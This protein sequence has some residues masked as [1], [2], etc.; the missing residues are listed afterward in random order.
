VRRSAFLASGAYDGRAMF[1]NL[2][3]M[4]TILAAGGTISTPLDL[5]VA[6]RPPSSEHFLSQR[7]RQAYDDFAIPARIAAFLAVWPLAVGLAARGRRRVV[8]GGAALAVV[9]AEAGRRRAGGAER[10][11]VTASLLAP[12]W[13]AER[14]TCAWLALGAKLQGGVRYGSG[15]LEHSATPMRELRRRYAA[16]SGEEG[17]GSEASLGRPLSTRKPA[18]L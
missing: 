7:I 8:L 15:R 1:E 12:V 17:A 5:Y 13:I 6:R 16:S 14:S 11:P 9:A 10:F 3:L 18:T 4:R 2:E